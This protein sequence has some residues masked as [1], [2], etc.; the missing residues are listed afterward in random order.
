MSTPKFYTN[1]RG[2]VISCCNIIMITNCTTVYGNIIVIIMQTFDI[3]S[4]TVKNVLGDGGHGNDTDS[5]EEDTESQTG[6]HEESRE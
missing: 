5:D 2:W 1:G 4:K 6:D 3:R